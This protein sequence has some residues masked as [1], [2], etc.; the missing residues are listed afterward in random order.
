[1]ER[2]SDEAERG[3]PSSGALGVPGASQRGMPAIVAGV[4]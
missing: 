1:M 2:S 3:D 4:L